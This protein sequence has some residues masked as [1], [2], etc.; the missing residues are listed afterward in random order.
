MRESLYEGWVVSL[1]DWADYVDGE[2]VGEVLGV[3]AAWQD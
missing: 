3:V 1:D 2:V